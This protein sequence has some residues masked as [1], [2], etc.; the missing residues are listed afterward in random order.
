MGIASFLEVRFLGSIFLGIAQLFKEPF[1]CRRKSKWC[2][3]ERWSWTTKI[4][5]FS[6]MLIKGWVLLLKV[7]L[8]GQ[9]QYYIMKRQKAFP[10]LVVVAAAFFSGALLSYV[11][12]SQTPPAYHYATHIAPGMF[13]NALS[14]VGDYFFPKDVFVTGNVVALNKLGVGVP[15]PQNTVDIKDLGTQVIM[16]LQPSSSSGYGAI[17]LL[18]AKMSKYANKNL[19][20]DINDA[21]PEGFEFKRDV[22]AKRIAV[23][24]L[25]ADKIDSTSIP[26][27][28]R[29]YIIY[30][31]GTSRV[32]ASCRAG[33]TA[34]GGSGT[35]SSSSS[36][37]QTCFG[38]GNTCIMSSYPNSNPANSYIV[39]CT[40]I[41]IGASATVVCMK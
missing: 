14:Q 16:N 21:S 41:S 7:Y 9:G 38:A 2:C 13:G 29:S 6:G 25:L 30:A 27:G 24:N 19:T 28:Q 3:L 18:D 34:V 32:V 4:F 31:A 10:L 37:M 22:F 1:H 36:L 40:G 8:L 39:S 20:F 23:S 17:V 12:V 5:F 15:S 26:A 33:D 35:C 11:A